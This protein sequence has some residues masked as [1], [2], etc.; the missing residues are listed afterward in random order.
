MDDDVYDEYFTTYLQANL[1]SYDMTEITVNSSSPQL[2]FGR[3]G[4]DEHTRFIEGMQLFGKDW[5]NVTKVVQTRSV[6]QVRSHAQKFS[7]KLKKAWEL[8][9]VLSMEGQPVY[10]NDFLTFC[11]LKASKK[12]KEK[13]KLCE[14]QGTGSVPELNAINEGFF[15]QLTMCEEVEI[16]REDVYDLFKALLD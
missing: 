7:L 5:I 15:R 16:S 12:A 10:P 13:R 11:S 9:Q 6:V 8:N 3:W 4:N 2:K 1:L 14:P